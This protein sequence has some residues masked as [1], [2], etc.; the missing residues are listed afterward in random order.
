MKKKSTFTFNWNTW[1]KVYEPQRKVLPKELL[2]HLQVTLP[3]QSVALPLQPS[4]QMTQ[5]V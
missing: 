1:K 4:H 5:P 3:A 2:G